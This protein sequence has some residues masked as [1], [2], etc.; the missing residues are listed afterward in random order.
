[1]VANNSDF[2]NLAAALGV[3][4]ATFVPMQQILVDDSRLVIVM[5]EYLMQSRLE[6]ASESDICCHDDISYLPLSHH[7]F[8]PVS[9]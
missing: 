6:L 1:M 8:S 3:F 5:P 4:S 7:I 2:L 9:F